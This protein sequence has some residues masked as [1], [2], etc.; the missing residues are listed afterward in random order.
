MIG[1]WCIYDS[2]IWYTPTFMNSINHPFQTR[3]NNPRRIHNKH[4]SIDHIISKIGPL[5]SPR[6][7]LQKQSLQFFVLT[8]LVTEFKGITWPKSILNGF[9]P[10][11]STT[12]NS[13]TKLPFP[14]L[15][16]K[17]SLVSLISQPKKCPKN[18]MC[19]SQFL[20]Q[21]RHN[22]GQSRFEVHLH[23]SSPRAS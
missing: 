14:S 15:P 17:P 16:F 7:I 12:F 5:C 9:G 21:H 18:I 11:P 1:G 3:H 6:N 22:H 20:T 13:S 19:C 10:F 4:N 2:S 23:L 8:S